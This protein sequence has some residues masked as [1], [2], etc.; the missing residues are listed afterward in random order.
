MN[1]L[2]N[3]N[4]V[5]YQAIIYPKENITDKKTYIGLM[6]TKWK[7]RY[8]NHEF[9]LSHEHLKHHTALSKQFWCFKKQRVNPCDRMVY[10][11]KIKY[12]K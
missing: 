5:I 11:E 6:S 9:T 3:L 2:R 1:G 7:E 12:S 10:F 8:S 4:N